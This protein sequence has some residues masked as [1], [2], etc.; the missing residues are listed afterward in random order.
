MAEPDPAREAWSLIHEMWMNNRGRLREAAGE[1]DLGP[2][3]AH[4][5][6]LLAD[7][8]APM[9]KLAC[10]LHCDPSNVTG[11]SDRLVERGLVE[12]HADPDDRRVKMLALTTEG[13]R[14]RAP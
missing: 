12:R 8:P 1:F 6:R 10:R 7:G 4:L 14:V 3:Q 13:D 5:L 11:L 9:R 2:R